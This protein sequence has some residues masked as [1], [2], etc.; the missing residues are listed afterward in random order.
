MQ[1]N[2]HYTKEESETNSVFFQHE[3]RKRR[4]N[5]KAHYQATMFDDFNDNSYHLIKELSLLPLRRERLW[6]SFT[7]MWTSPVDRV[8]FPVKIK[9]NIC[10][11]CL[12]KLFCLMQQF[13]PIC[14]GDIQPG[15]V[16]SHLNSTLLS[17][18]WKLRSSSQSTARS[19]HVCIP[20]MTFL[21]LQLSKH[22][23][24]VFSSQ[25]SQINRSACHQPM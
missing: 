11:R 16:I 21:L 18:L 5:Y 14:R 13:L 3:C 23:P 24:L 6:H 22:R 17:V 19:Y 20:T 1:D 8:L 12:L 10:L 25:G 15:L 4:Y 7:Q 2:L 9:Q